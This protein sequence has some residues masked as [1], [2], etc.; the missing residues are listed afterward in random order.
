[1][2]E[3]GGKAAKTFPTPPL[4]TLPKGKIAAVPFD[5]RKQPQ[6]ISV[7]VT[8]SGKNQSEKRETLF[9]EF[10]RELVMAS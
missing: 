8:E 7:V 9:Y 3:E 2:T 1:M 10:P 5:R 4:G 6:T